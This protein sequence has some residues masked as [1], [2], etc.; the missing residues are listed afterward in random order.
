MAPTNSLPTTKAWLGF[1]RD[2]AGCTPDKVE[3]VGHSGVGEFRG[4]TT[5]VVHD[6]VT[7]AT[8]V[9]RADVADFNVLVAMLPLTFQALLQPGA[10]Q[11]T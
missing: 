7:G 11:Q 2:L 9:I 3:L 4:A 10:A 5:L 8:V 1:C 6:R